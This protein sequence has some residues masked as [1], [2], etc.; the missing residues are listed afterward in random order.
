MTKP[1][2]KLPDAA[3]VGEI[4]EIKTL[5]SHVMETGLRKDRDGKVVPRGIINTFSARFGD[6]EFLN[7]QLHP[8]ISANPYL[9]FHFRVPGAGELQ[10]TWT[11]D[12]GRVISETV[13]I[14]V[15]A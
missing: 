1:R 3:K 10:L 9:A 4:I 14:N 13:K 8:G 12:G 5:I 7:V 15:T 11:E 2:I 6:I